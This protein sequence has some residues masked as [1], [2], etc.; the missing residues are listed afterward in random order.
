MPTSIWGGPES[1][2]ADETY[3]LSLL[4]YFLRQMILQ[5][6]A[7][8]ACL[9]LS[10]E[11]IGQMRIQAHVRLCNTEVPAPTI[12]MRRLDH[13]SYDVKRQGGRV[14][15]NLLHHDANSHAFARSKEAQ[16]VHAAVPQT[17]EIEDVSPEQ[18]ELF[19][20]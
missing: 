14:T 15:V 2:N 1:D 19:S 9:A 11:S 6:G 7:Q 5:F 16:P 3:P 13:N 8:G 17:V 20:V 18:C 4:K 10:D 12:P